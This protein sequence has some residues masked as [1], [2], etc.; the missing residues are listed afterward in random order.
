ME[1]YKLRKDIKYFTKRHKDI[2]GYTPD[3]KHPQTFNEK[4]VHRILFDRNP[5]YTHLA[6][7]LKARI[8]IATMLRDI[9][10]NATNTNGGGNTL[11]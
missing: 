2:F 5:I 1:A 6:D 7:K 8:Y 3:F 9:N 10:L 11:T 4:I